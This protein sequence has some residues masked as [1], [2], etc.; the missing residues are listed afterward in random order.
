MVVLA[1]LKLR[2]QKW[3][4][5]LRIHFRD[6]IARMKGMG[7]DVDYRWGDNW[8][9]DSFS[10]QKRIWITDGSGGLI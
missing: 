3:K 9:T 1:F 6:G 7:K 2:L 8:I 10:R 5:G 4:T